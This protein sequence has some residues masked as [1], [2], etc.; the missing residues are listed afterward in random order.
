[1]RFQPS[2]KGYPVTSMDLS[3]TDRLSERFSKCVALFFDLQEHAFSSYVFE[4]KQKRLKDFRKCQV[5]IHEAEPFISIAC[6]SVIRSFLK[7]DRA[8]I[9]LSRLHKFLC[10]KSSFQDDHEIHPYF[11]RSCFKVK[12]LY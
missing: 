12:S 6:K 4:A 11:T 7:T 2:L 3:Y 8:Q 5:K 1:M 10:R 9:P